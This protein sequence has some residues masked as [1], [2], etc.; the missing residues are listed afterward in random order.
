MFT[1]Q[2]RIPRKYTKAQAIHEY[3]IAAMNARKPGVKQTTLSFANATA[4]TAQAQ[5][6][7]RQTT[8]S[9]WSK[10]PSPPPRHN[11]PQTNNTTWIIRPRMG[12]TGLATRPFNGDADRLTEWYRNR[13]QANAG[14]NKPALTLIR[15]AWSLGPKSI[16]SLTFAGHVTFSTVRAYTALF[17]EKFDNKHI[18]HPGSNALKNIALFNIPIQR[19]NLG[20][21]QTRRELFDELIRGGTLAGLNLF[22][23]PVW[24]P[25]TLTNPEATTGAAHILVYDSTGSAAYKFFNKQT[26][27]Y[28]KCIAS[29]TAIPPKPFVQCTRCHRL[30]HE[31]AVCTRPHNAKICHHCGSNAH[32]SSQHKFQ[33]K[34][35]HSGP[36]CDCPPRCFLCRT[37]RKPRAQYTGHTALDTSCPL[38]KYTFTLSETADA[39]RPT[40][41]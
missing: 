38:R 31:V 27:M 35:Q 28:N 25:K 36:T 9:A 39:N 32:A 33:C 34:E 14:P 23:G 13:L 19:D 11:S 40:N 15:R 37:A 3:Q 1:F 41:V 20:N 4:S 24:T 2:H 7:P 6:N 10:S 22:D 21:P 26:F 18:F 30:G 12:T 5:A 16:F 29:Q 8:P 17:L